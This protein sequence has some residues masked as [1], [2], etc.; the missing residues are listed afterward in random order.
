V[1]EPV[2]ARPPTLSY[3]FRRFAKRNK[4]AFAAGTGIAAALLTGTAVSTWQA[5]RAQRGEARA[6]AAL[7]ELSASAPAFAAMA[8]TL[9]AR[10]QFDEAIGKLEVAIKLRPDVAEY[11][12]AKADLLE[13]QFRFAEAAPAYRK[14][15]QL[16]PGENRAESNAVLCERLAAEMATNS[17][18]SRGSLTELF[19]RMTQEQR[20]AA[21]M[22]KAGRLLGKENDLLLSYW[23]ERLKDLPIPPENPLKQRLTISKEGE[24]ALDLSNTEMGDLE[25][26]RGI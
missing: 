5:L 9:V 21:E 14:V 17:S 10:E 2:E 18:L 24:L 7:L 23:L 12:L 11:V 4:A 8:T 3:R 20:S 13:S 1:N 25:P 22:L 19:S 16:D 15:L 6:N 26:L